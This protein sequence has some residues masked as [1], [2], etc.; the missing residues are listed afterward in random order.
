MHIVVLLHTTTMSSSYRL[1]LLFILNVTFSFLG[2]LFIIVDSFLFAWWSKTKIQ[3][4]RL[5]WK[6]RSC[7]CTSGA[8]LTGLHDCTN[9]ETIRD[10]YDRWLR[11]LR[12]VGKVEASSRKWRSVT[13]YE[14]TIAWTRWRVCV[15]VE[16]IYKDYQITLLN[17]CNLSKNWTKT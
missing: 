3:K 5:S 13:G 17:D 6:F 4:T 9:T 14:E 2:N 10:F 16:G 8:T 1:I 7:I 12:S 11:L 15:E